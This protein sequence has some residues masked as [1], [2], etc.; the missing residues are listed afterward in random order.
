MISYGINIK[1]F[2]NK[3]K[4][5][6][7]VSRVVALLSIVCAHCSMVNDD[8]SISTRFIGG[9]FQCF[10]P[11]GVSLFFFI[12]G[13]LFARNNKKFGAFWRG[14]AFSLFIPWFFCSTV[15]YLYVSLR[16]DSFDLVDC[17]LSVLGYSS[18]F[19]FCFSLVLIYMILFALPK[20]KASC[21]FLV[22]L[23]LS[24]R[25]PLGLGMFPKNNFF[26]YINPLN[27]L[28]I[29][30]IGMLCTNLLCVIVEEKANKVGAFFA[31]FIV[32][33]I[34]LLFVLGWNSY[35]GIY[36]SYTHI[37]YVFIALLFVVFG[38]TLSAVLVNYRKITSVL[39]WVGERSF[40][41]YLLHELGFAG[42]ITNLCSRVDSPI[43]VIIRPFLVIC[44]C[45]L[46]IELGRWGAGVIGMSRFYA[47]LVG[48]RF[49]K[50][51][52]EK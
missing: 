41:V 37:F 29:F 49:V 24:Y 22:V 30:C 46:A 32:S 4:D 18:S 23:S 42:L 33:L 34:A 31:T 40:S 1:P 9:F 43:F 6:I 11:W 50:D 13:M 8:V 44:F 48:S 26:A 19:W 28:W 45:L 51:G 47:L 3:S 14:K 10:G 20:N 38:I 12:S 15:V 35:K 21:V 25:I 7:T 5:I 17:I 36:V 52:V 27:W 2:L 16:K 39:K